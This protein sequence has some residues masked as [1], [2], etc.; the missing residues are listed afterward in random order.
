MLADVHAGLVADL[1]H[2]VAYTACEG[3]G[4]Y[5]DGTKIHTSKTVS[6]DEAVVGL[7]LNT[8]KIKEFVPKITSLI[9]KTNIFA[10]LAP[11]RLNSAMSRMV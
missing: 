2:D 4:A 9:E 11:T 6:L 8:Y 10:T 3:K 5:R 7:D 1:F